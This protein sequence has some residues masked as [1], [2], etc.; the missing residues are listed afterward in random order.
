MD[1][2]VAL[3]LQ[4]EDM[5]RAIYGTVP[6]ALVGRWIHAAAGLSACSLSQILQ[7]LPGILLAI[8]GWME[9]ST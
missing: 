9:V 7:C 8:D 1:T 5:V 4:S 2:R 3:Y 6:A